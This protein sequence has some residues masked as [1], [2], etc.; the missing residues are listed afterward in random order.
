MTGAGTSGTVQ[1]AQTVPEAP[2][3]DPDATQSEDGIQHP[4]GVVH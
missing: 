2:A 1:A 4:G 3:A